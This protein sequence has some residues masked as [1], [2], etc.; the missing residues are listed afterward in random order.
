MGDSIVF[1]DTETGGLLPQHPTIQIA[2]V[3]VDSGFVELESFE[4]KVQFD[5]NACESE[6]LR[7]NSYHPEKWRGALPEPRAL[8]EFGDFL[9]RYRCVELVSR[10]GKAYSVAR[11]AGHNVAGFDLERVA[12]AFKRYGLFFPIDFRTV[13]D[14]RYGAVWHFEIN[15]GRPKDFKLTGLAEHFGISTDGAHDALSDVRM[16]IALARKLVGK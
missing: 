16:T 15:G 6:A 10:A 12:A 1:F 13:L 5:I 7:I 8:Q 4:R 14:T 2:A 11:V 3:A 9:G